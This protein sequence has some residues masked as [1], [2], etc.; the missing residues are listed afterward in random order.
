MSQNAKEL[1]FEEASRELLVRGIGKLV[2]TAGCTLGP[3]GRNVGLEKSWGAPTITNDGAS[4]A[5]EISLEDQ[6]ENMGASIAK[7]VAEKIKEKGGDGTTSGLVLLHALVSHGVKQVSSGTNP[8]LL[9]RGMEKAVEA[10]V[11]SIE[12][13][14]IPIANEADTRNIATVS[15][16][17][18]QEIGEMI[19]KAVAQVGREG[20]IT[21][22]EAKG[23]KTTID[24]VEGMKFDRGYLSGYFCTGEEDKREAV[25]EQAK[26]LIIDKK[27]SNIHDLL[28]I[29]ERAAMTAQPLLIIAED[30][31]GDALSTLVINKLRGTLKV[32]AVKAPGFGDRRKAQLQD[33]AVLTGGTVISEEAGI[34]LKEAND[35]L[36]GSA[37]RIIVTKDQTTIVHGKGSAEAIAARVKQLEAE[38]EKASSS[39]DKEKIEE[40]KAKLAGGVAVIRVGA[41]TE[42]EMKQLKSM[43]HDSL[44]STRAALQEGIVPGG[45]IALLHAREAIASLGL[46]GDEAL[47]AQIVYQSCEAPFRQIVTNAGYDGSV[48][49]HEV[50]KQGKN[51]G[52]NAANEKVEDLLQAGVIDPA[53]VVRLALLHA[54]SAAEIVLITEVLI[55]NAP[56]EEEEESA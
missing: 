6:Y 11:K 10:I 25:L 16:S 29:L 30:I 12:R 54:A 36:L 1:I 42:Q 3:K 52:F 39:Y 49:L 28:P 14:A 27:V 47:G 26:V 13:A 23:T 18:N 17:G 21:I 34:S 20:V 53:K 35:Q 19:A 8:T 43:Y 56:E 5:K 15:A 45:G 33:I 32:C 50:L 51:V 40:R 9:K 24:H 41:L 38:A 31:E 22:E 55:G 7:E 37:E 2:Q 46:S 48:M 4:I 44:N